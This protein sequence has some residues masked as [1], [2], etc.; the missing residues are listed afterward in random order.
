MSEM[1]C[2]MEQITQFGFVLFI[3]IVLTI[4][5]KCDIWGFLG[6]LRPKY[7]TPT[8]WVG[9]SLWAVIHLYS[10]VVLHME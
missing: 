1:V 6:M 4:Q 2:Q 3:N 10:T 8:L 5:I 9:F 7:S